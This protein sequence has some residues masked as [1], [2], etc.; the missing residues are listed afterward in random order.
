MTADTTAAQSGTNEN[1]S[2][3]EEKKKTLFKITMDKRVDLALTIILGLFGIFL[4]VMAST[5]YMGR[6][7]D[8]FTAKGAPYVTGVFITICSIILVVLQIRSWSA[9]PGRF[10]VSEAAKEDEEGYTS[11]WKRAFAVVLAATISALFWE[12]IGYVIMTPLFMIV[13]L[14]IM[15]ER[16]WK[17]IIMFGLI[18]GLASWYLFHQILVFMIPMGILEPLARSLGL[19]M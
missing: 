17:K 13:A 18:F 1:T 14:L 10:V 7:D 2:Q 9:I 8:M 11:S 12:S 5:F 16:S 15:G 6:V 3:G 19:L 4:C